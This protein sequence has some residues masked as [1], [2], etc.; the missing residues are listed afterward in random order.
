MDFFEVPVLENEFVRLEPL[1][2]S[3]HDDLVDAVQVNELWRTWY[4]H[5]PS[6]ELMADVIEQRLEML[7]NEQ[8][9]PFAVVD[10]ESN[11]A[12]G[13]TSYLNIEAAHKRLEIGSTWLGRNAQGT[14]INP[15]SK[16][17]LLTRAFVE[18]G[19]IA[20]EFR[21]HWHNHQS[22]AAI[23]KLGAKQDGVLRNHRIFEN[24]TVRD[25]VVFS[26]ID[27]EWP[28]VRFAL[29]ERLRR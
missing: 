7:V 19:C 1:D 3:H 22:R 17:L 4:T 25:T 10:P 6:P 14:R 27:T 11:R 24:G 23:E 15:A 13:M 26:I 8:I 20:V 21:T 5:I 12:V 2:P 28:T 29:T 18:L 16:L 9:V